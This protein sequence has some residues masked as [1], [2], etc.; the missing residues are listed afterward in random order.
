MKDESKLV[1]I[2]VPIYNADKYLDRCI[3]SIVEQT[4]HNLEFILVD[5]GSNDKSSEICK[6][7][8]KNDNRVRYFYQNNAGVSSARNLGLDKARGD[9]I[10]FVDADDY[11]DAFFC[12]KLLNV[13]VRNDSDIVCCTVRNICIDGQVIVSGRNSQDIFVCSSDKFEYYGE[14]ERRSVWGAIYKKEVVQTLRF[15]KKIAV[16]EDA[17]FFAM[18]VCRS[19]TIAY[20]DFPL[21]NYTVLEN[22]AYHG[23]FDKK[24]QTELDAW[25]KIC[26]IFQNSPITKLSAE[27]QFAEICIIML[28]KYMGDQ[29]FDKGVIDEIIH[30]YRKH[31]F[32]LTQY[33]RIKHRKIFKHI[34][35]GLFPHLYVMYRRIKT[36]EKKKSVGIVTIYDPK[37]N[38]GNRLQ[39]YAVQTVLNKMEFETV[40]YSFE[41]QFFGI[42]EKIKYLAQLL[43]GFHLPGDKFYWRSMPPRIIRFNMFNEKYIHTEIIHSI[44]AVKPRDYYVLGSDQVWNATWYGKDDMKSKMYLLTFAKP[45]QR[46]CLSPSFGIEQFPNEWKSYFKKNL[47]DFPKL[48]VREEAGAKII[49]DL[50]GREAT[51]LVDPT[52]LLT[53]N[54]WIKV[55]KKPRGAKE[56]Y[57]L[58]YFLSPKCDKAKIQLDK[59]REGRNVYELMNLHDKVA[60]TAGPSE[61]LWLF[62]HADMILTDSFHACVF[63]FLFNKPFVVYDRYWN[64]ENMNSRLD[65]LLSKFSL[66]RKYAGSGLPNDIW[67]HD[68]TE[69]Y[70]QLEKER[71]KSIDFLKKAL[72]D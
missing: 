28:A 17:V 66:E 51:V 35:I 8:V 41:K 26:R 27:A 16:G 55:A 46:V 38:Y 42:K 47:M 44:E 48:S 37:P 9:Y 18:A 23:N 36:N 57:I 11:L 39:N 60:G 53:K 13:L 63:S 22:S 1:S 21:Y 6:R 5:D 4:Y 69:G 12:E 7:W 31:L 20:F 30:I 72:E 2:I 59:I 10:A 71:K 34:M 65:T 49:R 64:E 50:T 25:D 33:D 32:A 56:G 24:K 62:D 70:N 68:Y 45:E 52:M 43:T 19:D 15:P 29:E 58:T 67:E 3:K 54:E 14:I 61:F 40:S